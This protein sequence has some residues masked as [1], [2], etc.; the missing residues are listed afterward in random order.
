MDKIKLN[1]NLLK[2]KIYLKE[3]N[4]ENIISEM[5]NELIINKPEDHF[6]FMIEFLN[7]KSQEKET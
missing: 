1:E 4:I 3:H 5:L 2:A 6:K 7:K